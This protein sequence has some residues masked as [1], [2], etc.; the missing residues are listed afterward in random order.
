MSAN[1]LPSGL[2]CWYEESRA[3]WDSSETAD[4]DA[5]FLLT[6]ELLSVWFRV[7]PEAAASTAT[8]AARISPFNNLAR[9]SAWR[10]ELVLSEV[11]GCVDME[12][13]FVGRGHQV[14]LNS[15]LTVSTSL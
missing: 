4:S 15:G 10:V 6:E 11:V 12:I 1:T 3:F 5:V 14:P 8:Q 7:A 13:P 9:A 2:C